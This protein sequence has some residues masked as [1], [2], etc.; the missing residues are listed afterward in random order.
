MKPNLISARL[1]LCLLIC[2]GTIPSLAS[3]QENPEIPSFIGAWSGPLVLNSDENSDLEFTFAFDDGI[4]TATLINT[5]MGI[6]GMP[7]DTVRV[8]GLSLTLRFQRLDLEVLGTLR[9]DESGKHIIRIDGEWF[10]G[11]EMVPVVLLPT[12]TP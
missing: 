4:Y 2:C 6:Y 7:A 12:D 8:R 3:A 11:A 10:Q 9:L 5:E 1:I